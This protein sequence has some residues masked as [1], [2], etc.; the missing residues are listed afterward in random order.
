M[1]D[2][3][4]HEHEAEP[5]AAVGRAHSEKC[6][7]EHDAATGDASRETAS[8]MEESDRHATAS[9]EGAGPSDAPAAASSEAGKRVRGKRTTAHSGWTRQ[10]AAKHDGRELATRLEADMADD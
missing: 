4:K 6:R 8:E 5:P 2:M 1:E 9:S 7:E 10:K 3:S